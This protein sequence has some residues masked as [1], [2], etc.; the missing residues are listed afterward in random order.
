MDPSPTGSLKLLQYL[1]RPAGAGAAGVVLLFG[2]GFSLVSWAGLFGLPVTLML[3]SWFWKYAFVLFDSTVRGEPEA[4]ALDIQ[5]LN[6]LDEL[7]PLAQLIIMAL[8]GFVVWWVAATFGTP[9]G[10]VVAA[11]ALIFL[12]ASV[13]MLGLE[14]NAFKAL[15]LLALGKLMR[16]LGL[17]YPA[18][19]GIIAVYALALLFMFRISL[20]PYFQ[21]VSAMFAMLSVFSALAGAVYLRRDELGLSV[22]HSREIDAQRAQDQVRKLDEQ[23]LLHAYGL[24]RA[25]R[26]IDA[27]QALNEWLQSRGHAREAYHWAIERTLSWGDARYRTRLTQE[28]LERL[29]DKHETGEALRVLEAALQHDPG[30]RPKTLSSTQRLA[31]LATAGGAPGVARA[32]QSGLPNRT[33]DEPAAP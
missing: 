17:Q 7:R 29:L 8:A 19:L 6:P 12:P 18:L 31:D 30:F 4:P 15:N 26:H 11:L 16:G 10:L 1:L 2:I 27:W 24:T 22:W 9:A 20:W 28:F 5:M 32:M 3:L 23:A 13:A 25:N 14:R 33:K 21:Y